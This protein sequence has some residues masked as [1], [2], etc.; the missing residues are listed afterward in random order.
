MAITDLVKAA[1]RN[2]PTY[3]RPVESNSPI[4][5]LVDLSDSNVA[6]KAAG[7]MIDGESVGPRFDEKADWENCKHRKPLGGKDI[8]TQFFINCRKETCSNKFIKK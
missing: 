3:T 5:N 4:K 8:C 7:G 2:T 1:R 6:T